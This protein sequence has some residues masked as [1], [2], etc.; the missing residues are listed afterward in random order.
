MFIGRLNKLLSIILIILYTLL[1]FCLA[2][3]KFIQKDN[4]NNFINKIEIKDITKIDNT[5]VKNSEF[6]KDIEKNVIKNSVL[7]FF[8]YEKKY[9]KKEVLEIIENENDRIEVKEELKEKIKTEIFNECVSIQD[10]FD[11]EI[12]SNLKLFNTI[13]S[14]INAKTLIIILIIFFTGLLVILNRYSFKWLLYNSLSQLL[15][16][17]LCTA[18]TYVF[19][20]V[21]N[22]MRLGSIL[23]LLIQNI[24]LIF[25]S[26]II[27]VII[28]IVQFILFI[29]LFNI[30]LKKSLKEENNI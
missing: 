10:S 29:I 18:I 17:L 4:L 8:K 12:A 1:F 22:K 15:S 26:K 16:F 3:N 25:K 19:M 2:F 20:F 21:T 14:F 7:S 9:T 30:K 13:D 28:P 5:Y 27:L 23:Y 24:Q 11:L 6:L